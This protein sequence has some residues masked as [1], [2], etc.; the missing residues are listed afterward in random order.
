LWRDG[1][2]SPFSRSPSSGEWEKVA[3]GRMREAAGTVLSY[4]LIP[5][6]MADWMNQRWNSR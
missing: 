4:P 1:C 5:L 3:E 2:H 6:P